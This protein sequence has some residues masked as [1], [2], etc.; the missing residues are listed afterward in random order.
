MRK[1]RFD[2][3]DFKV[4]VSEG[5]MYKLYRI[6]SCTN[7][8][9]LHLGEKGGYIAEG[10][11][12]S[13]EGSCWIDRLSMIHPGVHLSGNGKLFMSEIIGN[14]DITGGIYDIALLINRTKERIEYCHHTYNQIVEYSS[15]G[16]S[17]SNNLTIPREKLG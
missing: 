9:G 16:I 14:F 7:K 1:Y 10:A 5:N 11:T 17:T 6:Y 4:R 8:Y 15:D 12:L 13:Q 2:K 3:S